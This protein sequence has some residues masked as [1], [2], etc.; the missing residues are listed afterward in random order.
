MALHPDQL[1]TFLAVI[2]HGSFSRAAAALH[3]SQSTVSFQV[4]ALEDAVGTR[5]FDR[6]TREIRLTDGGRTLRPFAR[7]ILEL[8]GEARERLREVEGGE[9]GQVRVAASSIPAD[10]LLP[11]ALARHRSRWPLHSVTIEVSD[12]G[13]ALRQL[14][15]GDVDLAVVGTAPRDRRIQARA[16]AGDEVVLVAATGSPFAP[17][18]RLTRAALAKVPILTREPGSGTAAAVGHLLP[19]AEV[20]SIQIGSSAG[21]KRCVELRLGLAFLSRWAVEDELSRGSLRVVAAPGLPV[22]RRFWLARLRGVTPGKPARLLAQSIED[23]DY[24]HRFH[25]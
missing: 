14:L 20:P 6:A 25:R 11:L 13:S 16:F 9:T 23:T 21:L 15:D 18:G 8:G 22:R 10:H 2:A 19:A 24:S 5:L 17:A 12:S 3:M 1:R 7:R 4:K